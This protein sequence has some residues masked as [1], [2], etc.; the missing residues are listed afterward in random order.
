MTYRL[1]PT[2]FSFVD[3]LVKEVSLRFNKDRFMIDT[4]NKPPPKDY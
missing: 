3:E 1:E 4:P 2:S